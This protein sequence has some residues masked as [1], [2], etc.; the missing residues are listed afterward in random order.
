VRRL[1]VPC[2]K[3]TGPEIYS[4]DV[5]ESERKLRDVFRRALTASPSVV[6]IDEIDAVCPR[7]DDGSDVERRVVATLLTAM[8]GLASTSPSHSIVVLATTSRPN[9]LEPALR[10]PGR[11]DK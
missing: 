8:D 6:F 2:F 4:S 5:G 11:F 3:V 7:R 1:R 10:R 9:A